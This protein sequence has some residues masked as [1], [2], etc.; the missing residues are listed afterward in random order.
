MK[1]AIQ[2]FQSLFTRNA[3]VPATTVKTEFIYQPKPDFEL[4]RFSVWF[5][6]RSHQNGRFLLDYNPR[7]DKIVES[8]RL[9]GWMVQL[10]ALIN[11]ELSYS[12]FP[13]RSGSFA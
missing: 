10:Q 6:F 2:F 8:L 12:I 9:E 11:G 13:S 4:V 7:Y 1:K 5:H 3:A